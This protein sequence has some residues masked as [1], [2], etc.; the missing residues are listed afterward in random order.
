MIAEPSALQLREGQAVALEDRGAPGLRLPALDRDIDVSRADL[1]RL[2]ALAV[3]LGGPSTGTSLIRLT[4]ARHDRRARAGERLVEEART[5]AAP[6]HMR[7]ERDA[8]GVERLRRQMLGE[9]VAHEGRYLLGRGQRFVRN[10][11]PPVRTAPTED[12]RLVVQVGVR[13]GDHSAVR[14]GPALV[15]PGR[16][17]PVLA[18]YETGRGWAM[19]GRL[20]SLGGGAWC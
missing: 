20:R 18:C 13:A 5:E 11:R 2:D 7:A 4:R 14:P 16:W 1:H 17:G 15:V 6:R 3:R 8:E 19:D 10:L 9:L 12:A